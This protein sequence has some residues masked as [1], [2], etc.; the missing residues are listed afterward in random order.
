MDPAHSHPGKFIKAPPALG[1][2]SSAGQSCFRW[3]CMVSL[4]VH[5]ILE[6]WTKRKEEESGTERKGFIDGPGLY[7]QVTPLTLN[8]FTCAQKI[9]KYQHW[10]GT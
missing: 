5:P 8:V 6:T 2:G 7:K 10:Y 9:H 1:T 3:V 4:T